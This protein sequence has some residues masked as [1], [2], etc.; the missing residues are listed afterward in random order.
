VACR[1]YYDGDL[2][3]LYLMLKYTGNMLETKEKKRALKIIAIFNVM[4]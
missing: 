1:K 4:P 2:N 3:V